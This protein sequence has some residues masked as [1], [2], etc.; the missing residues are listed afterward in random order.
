MSA[1]GTKFTFVYVHLFT[2]FAM[3]SDVFLL[4]LENELGNEED[5]DDYRRVLADV[6]LLSYGIFQAYNFHIVKVFT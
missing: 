1:D 2:H 5:R 6:G 4:L 3:D